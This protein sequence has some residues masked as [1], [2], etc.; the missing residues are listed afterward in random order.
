[1]MMGCENLLNN[2]LFMCEHL[3]SLLSD[4][5]NDILKVL[6]YWHPC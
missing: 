4:S 6:Y 5:E 2:I 3:I 1:M